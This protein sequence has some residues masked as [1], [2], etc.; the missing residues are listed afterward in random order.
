MNELINELSSNVS[1]ILHLVEPISLRIK[2]HNDK[3]M[4]NDAIHIALDILAKLDRN[5]VMD[6]N[7]TMALIVKKVKTLLRCKSSDDILKRRA[8]ETVSAIMMIFSNIL[9]SAFFSNLKLLFFVSLQMVCLTYDH[10]YSRYS[11]IGF[12]AFGSALSSKRDKDGY[13]FA[14]FGL[15]LLEKC[16][17]KENIPIVHNIFYTLVS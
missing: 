1:N 6:K 12:A 16:T 14:K 15:I 7:L 13:D 8:D 5:L 11:S 17:I 2:F 10:G 9:T 4:Y 3:R